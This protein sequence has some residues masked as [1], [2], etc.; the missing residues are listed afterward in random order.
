MDINEARRLFKE[1]EI[2]SDAQLRR[3]EAA[4]YIS[5]SLRKLC[6]EAYMLEVK[7]K[8]ELAVIEA[9]NIIND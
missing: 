4:K 7:I 3:I 5:D 2:E 1:A 8:C 9:R 6:E